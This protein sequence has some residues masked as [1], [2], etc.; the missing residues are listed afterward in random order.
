MPIETFLKRLENIMRDDAGVDGTVQIL[1]QVV[2]MLFLRV[3][4]LKE[5]NWELFEDDYESPIKESCRW[6]NWAVGKSKNG[7]ITGEELL[8]FVNEELFP[9]LKGIEITV[10]TP[11]RVSIIVEMMEDANNYM[12]DGVCLRR[13]INLINEVKLDDY[14]ESH[15]FNT[16]Y[17]ELLK[18]L[19][20]AGKQGEYYTPRALTTFITNKVNPQ[21]GETIADFACGTG[22]FLVDTINH[23]KEQ[24]KSTRD[25]EILQNSIL[26]IEKKQLPYMLCT[27][28]LLLNGVDNPNIIHGNS[29]DKNV[30]DYTKEEMVDVILMNPPYGGYE[31]DNILSNFPSNLRNS[32]T[33]D[34]FMIEILYR[35]KDNGRCGIILPDGFLFGSDNSKVSIK[36]KL[37]REYNLHT[38]IRL[39]G[40]IFAPYTSIATNILFFDKTE[41]TKETWFYRFDLP[42]GYKSFSKTKPLK[43]EHMK[44]IEEWWN[45]RTEIKDN[46]TETYKAKK[47]T[48]D[49]LIKSNYN[50]DL[51][52]FPQ[53]EEIVLEPL[54]TIEIFQNKRNKLD[55]QMDKKLEEIL[56]LLNNE[57]L[58]LT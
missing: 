40:S 28:N 45:N 5:E 32:E 49:E 6:R 3:Y 57:D 15:A 20:T 35:L 37:L 9:T 25:E 46:G 12:K 53:K 4:D 39:C 34:L 7:Q 56:E 1:S 19:Q 47:Y 23:L 52:G 41:G 42:E 58:A 38:V 27:T 33:A 8:T 17:E 16:I 55:N 50:L 18:K 36:E 43:L 29:L 31:Q 54:E 22:G 2:W 44:C 13:V 21:L 10:N 51:C 24:V 48:I 11:R 26:G 14:E 30:R